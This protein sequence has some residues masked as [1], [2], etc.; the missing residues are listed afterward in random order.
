MTVDTAAGGTVA[1]VVDRVSTRAHGS[2]SVPCA[3]M[4]VLREGYEDEPRPDRL[5]PRDPRREEVMDAH[6]RA[7][8]RGSSAYRDPATGLDVMT[9]SYLAERGFCCS[10]G[11]R[12]CPYE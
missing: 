10:A 12:H 7:V 4:D 2:S 5:D 11:C 9:A 3:G 6:R 1:G 8:A